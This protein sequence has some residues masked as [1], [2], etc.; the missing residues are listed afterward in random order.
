LT[1]G[2]RFGYGRIRVSGFGRSF[3]YGRN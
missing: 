1:F 2:L 3:G